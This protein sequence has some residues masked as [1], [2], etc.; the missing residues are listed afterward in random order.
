MFDSFGEV[1]MDA[2]IIKTKERIDCALIE[3]LR[4]K[5]LSEITVSALCKKAGINRNTFYAHYHTPVD[6]IEEISNDLINELDFVA[7]KTADSLNIC[8]SICSYLYEKRD[9]FKVISS[10]N[11]DHKYLDIAVMRARNSSQ[12]RS[13]YSMWNDRLSLRDYY[14]E[15]VIGGCIFVLQRWVETGMKE[16]PQEMGA[17]IHNILMKCTS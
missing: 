7:R 6:V 10:S 8:I 9:I 3:L 14:P 12:S 17:M 15:F 4:S 2:R 1:N 11:C 5:H 16:L 13:N